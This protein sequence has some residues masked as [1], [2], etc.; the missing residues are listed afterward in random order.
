MRLNIAAVWQE[1]GDAAA[2]SSGIADKLSHSDIAHMDAPTLA[3]FVKSKFAERYY[4]TKPEGANWIAE[5]FLHEELSG[6]LLLDCTDEDLKDYG[7]TGPKLRYLRS[8]IKGAC[9]KKEKP[10]IIEVDSD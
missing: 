9:V 8:L 3:E 5:R 10:D 6:S 1:P 7:F 2:T 4:S